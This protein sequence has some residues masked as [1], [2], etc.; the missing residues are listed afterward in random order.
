MK[1]LAFYNNKGGVG[2]TTTC[3]N[4]AYAFAEMGK[5]VLVAD[6]D[7]QWN[8]LNF[9]TDEQSGGIS[10]TRYKNLDV[11]A[12]SENLSAQIEYDFVLLDLPP[13][14]N[15]EV[16]EILSICDFVFVPIEVSAFSM[17]GIAKVT[18]LIAEANTKFGGCYMSRFNKKNAANLKLLDLL[19][20]SFGDKLLTAIV[21]QSNAIENSINYKIT[22]F[23]H[24]KWTSAVISL[25]DLAAEILER[26]GE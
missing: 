23:E 18:D 10:K 12:W 26:V 16:R 17:Q 4:V 15:K 21:P 11:V 22:A 19:K 13:T 9:F 6:C 20:D 8:C 24:M 1:I 2:K 5:R 14:R 7:S 25:G 3:I